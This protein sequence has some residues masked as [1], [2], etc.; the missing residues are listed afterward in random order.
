MIALYV[1]DLLIV[2][3]FKNEIQHIKKELN[4]R[5]EMK[6]LGEA[7]VILGIEIFRDGL[8]RKLFIGQQEYTKQVLKRFNM[9]NARSILT[10]MDKS[11]FACLHTEG[12]QAPLNIPYR[13]A[14][15]SLIYLVSCTRPDLAFS[16]SKLSQFLENPS[17]HHWSAVKRVLRYLWT[18][19]DH[20]IEFNGSNGLEAIGYS[21]S[22]NAGC[23][24]DRK[25]TSGYIFLLAEGAIKWKSKKLS[26]VATSSN[27]A[28]YIANCMASKDAVWLSRLMA[29]LHVE[30]KKLPITIHIDNNGAKTIAHNA[31]VND[32][33]MHSDVQYH[34]VR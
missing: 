20:G 4:S 30:D 15:G 14:V 3:N 28:E 32:R 33:I 11:T 29:Y 34:Y 18:T 23:T 13:Q 22:D 9:T 19:Q 8:N 17:S 12:E 5:L 1:D 25:L 24:L 31:T 6:D 2:G 7:R 10:P 16:V 26:I 21:D 27:E